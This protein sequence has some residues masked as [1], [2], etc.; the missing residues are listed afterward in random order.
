MHGVASRSYNVYDFLPAFDGAKMLS[1]DKYGLW[2]EWWKGYYVKNSKA[3]RKE[4]LY[5]SGPMRPPTPDIPHI[6]KDQRPDSSVRV[7]F[8]S[9]QLAV[10]EEVF[11]Y[12]EL[13][14]KEED[15][16]VYLTFR[17][18]RDGFE[19]WLKENH[20]ETLETVGKSN[21]LRDGINSAVDK[22]D[23]VVGTHSTA[24]L[25]SL[26]NLKPFV[27]FHTKK[28][29]DY[30]NLKGYSNAFKFYTE[31]T[32]ELIESIGESKNVSKETLK[33]LQNRFFGDPY[34]NGSKWVVEQA[35]QVLR[36]AL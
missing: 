12:L 13:L 8:V 20:P 19:V 10:P 14:L 7:L 1:V 21:I 15:I 5:V 11:P 9:E 29:G 22:C 17:S 28:W 25:E 26:F 4:Q 32:E 34:K 6:H 16:S 3:Y 30:F 36:Q 31:S 24:V 18:Y 27:F 35:E 2:S 23:V 33:K